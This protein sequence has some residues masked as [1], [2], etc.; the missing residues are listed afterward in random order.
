MEIPYVIVIGEDEIKEN[1]VTIK[2][3]K[4]GEEVKASNNEIDIIKKIE[5]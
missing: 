4:T 3:M 5:E 2:N 1:V